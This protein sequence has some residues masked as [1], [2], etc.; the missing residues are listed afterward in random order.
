M[1]MNLKLTRTLFSSQGI[2][3]FLSDESGK[4]L[5]NTLEHS[6]G[7]KTKI[8]E[9][10]FTCVRGK[11]RL[12]GMTHNF[13]TFEVTGVEGHDGLLFHWGNYNS[14]SQGCVLIGTDLGKNMITKSLQ[15]FAKFMMLQEGIDSFPLIIEDIR[16]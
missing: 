10:S 2:F 15:A 11:H 5:F 3:G 13:E 1:V 4:K 9:G 12:H 8:P 7:G 6:Y 14:D 16:T